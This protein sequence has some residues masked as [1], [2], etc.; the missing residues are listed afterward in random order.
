M[1][2]TFNPRNAGADRS[3]VSAEV[4]QTN[5]TPIGTTASSP[6]RSP[7]ENPRISG[8][9]GLFKAAGEGSVLLDLSGRIAYASPNAERFLGR[10]TAELQQHAFLDLV[11]PALKP[12][13]LGA[14]QRVCAGQA[15]PVF[16]TRW[17]DRIPGKEVSLATRVL[18]LA[19]GGQLLGI[20]VN[21]F[22]V[23]SRQAADL[24]LRGDFRGAAAMG[25]QSPFI[26]FFLDARGQCNYMTSA[27]TRVTGHPLEKAAG[28]GWLEVMPE[29]H[30]SEL[31]NEAGLAHRDRRGWRVQKPFTMANGNERWMD[32]AAAPV[33]DNNGA[34]VGYYGVLAPSSEALEPSMWA[35]SAV[36]NFV[37]PTFSAPEISTQPTHLGQASADHSPTPVLP[38]ISASGVTQA[39]PAMKVERHALPTV[40][41]GGPG[42]PVELTPDVLLGQKKDVERPIELVCT[43]PEIDKTTGLANRLLFAQ[44]VAATTAR[45][46]QDALTVSLSFIHVHGLDK[47]LADSG[48][49]VVGDYLFLLSKRLEATIRSIE[50]AGRIDTHV[51]GVLSINWL[52][53]EDLPILCRRL[54]SRLS[55]PLGGKDGREIVLPMHLGLAV[56]HYGETVDELFARARGSLENSYRSPD[57]F[58][59]DLGE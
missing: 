33:V 17:A 45:M 59:I 21:C 22:E 31:R 11:P 34:I 6:P 52:F 40:Q 12:V 4:M 13:F 32:C 51:F 18:A 53:K 15:E 30:R 9:S 57:T 20:N 42:G 44:H 2:E 27:W 39:S 19:E 50:I 47:H 54:L 10:K 43:Q 58:H 1:K 7:D 29:P 8:L 28:L 25:E 5:P 23:A 37:T 26:V 41:Q 55:E 24:A 14:F 38:N 16:E 46:Q 56:A 36:N 3:H 48:A 49:R 35:K